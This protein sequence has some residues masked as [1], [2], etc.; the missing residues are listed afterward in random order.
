MISNENQRLLEREL[1]SGEDVLYQFESPV[2]KRYLPKVN[3]YWARVFTNLYFLGFGVFLGWLFFE[4]E[5][6][7]RWYYLFMIGTVLASQVIIG[8]LFGTGSFKT[9]SIL[10]SDFELAVVTDRRVLIF[11]RNERILNIP[12]NDFKL[13]SADLESGAKVIRLSKINKY[14]YIPDV[15]VPDTQTPSLLGVLNTLVQSEV[16]SDLQKP[17]AE[18]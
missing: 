13:A 10:L 3:E 8:S 14:S 9:K 2:K 17:S 5:A 1:Q 6:D 16:P 7:T 11:D 4:A 15:L 12:L 18:A